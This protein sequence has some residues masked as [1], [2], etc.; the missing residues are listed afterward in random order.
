MTVCSIEYQVRL[1]KKEALRTTLKS[2]HEEETFIR[3]RAVQLHKDAQAKIDHINMMLIADLEYMNEKSVQVTEAIYEAESAI[4][5]LG[6]EEL[7]VNEDCEYDDVHEHR[8]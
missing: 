5:D 4:L 3:D 8:H 2:L 6:L 1:K 7:N